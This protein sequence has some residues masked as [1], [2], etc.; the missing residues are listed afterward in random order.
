MIS[1]RRL[2]PGSSPDSLQG[3][4]WRYLIALLVIGALLVVMPGFLPSYLLD[5][6]TKVLILSVFAVSLNI[7]W[8][9]GLTSLG[10]ATYF[11]WG[12]YVSAILIARLGIGNF[13]VILGTAIVSVIVVS[14][15]FGVIALHV[16]GVYFMMVTMALSQLV[17]FTS[18]ALVSITGGI[19]GIYGI[20]L[21]NLGFIQLASNKTLLFLGALY[22]GRMLFSDA[23]APLFDIR[24][25]H[26]RDTER[27]NKNE[28][29]RIQYVADEICR[30]YRFRSVR[31]SRRCFIQ[32]FLRSCL[33]APSGHQN[34]HHGD[35]HAH[36]GRF[37][38]IFRARARRNL[39]R[40]SG[41]FRQYLPS[42]QMAV[43]SWFGIH[44]LGYV[45]AGRDCSLFHRAMER[46]NTSK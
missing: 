36:S 20:S 8:D 44:I 10:H 37:Q 28:N 14:A 25:C 2:F 40:S 43:G 9:A 29:P 18:I 6:L 35:S 34:S 4:R 22:L 23:Q 13:W 24:L 17:Y 26:A 41:I 3:N 46:Q 45:P 31:G 11:G 30:L 15:I 19:N 42:Y 16:K 32:L 33:S 1:K 21:P 39:V 27:R 7:I 12:A 5:L 38:H